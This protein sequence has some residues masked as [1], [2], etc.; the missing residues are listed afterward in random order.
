MNIIFELNVLPVRLQI[1]AIK[2]YTYVRA[3]SFTIFETDVSNHCHKLEVFNTMIH[4]DISMASFAKFY[5]KVCRK[6]IIYRER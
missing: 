6:R 4:P 1:V 2:Q 3:Y 5:G